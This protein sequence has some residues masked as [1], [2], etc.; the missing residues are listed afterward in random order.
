MQAI[1]GGSQLSTITIVQSGQPDDDS[2]LTLSDNLNNG[3]SNRANATCP[4][5]ETLGKV[6][7]WF[8][9]SCFATPALYQI[10][11]LWFGAGSQ[12]WLMSTPT[13]PLIEDRKPFTNR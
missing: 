4:G 7:E 11:Q 13:S 1:A 8:N 5:V 2:I 12:P 3:M 6:S 10:R 9:T